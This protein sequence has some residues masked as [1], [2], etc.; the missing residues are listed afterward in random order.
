MT[1]TSDKL[2]VDLNLYQILLTIFLEIT[3]LVESLSKWEDFYYSL[4]T[5]NAYFNE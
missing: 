2:Q 5:D 3:L 4:F 1:E